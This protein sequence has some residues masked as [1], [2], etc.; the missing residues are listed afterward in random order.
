MGAID[1]CI[2]APGTT[3]GAID[4]DAIRRIDSGEI[5]ANKAFMQAGVDFTLPEKERMRGPRPLLGDGVCGPQGPLARGRGSPLRG[6][7]RRS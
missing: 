4:V 6:R 3:H 5:T 7:V 2:F 1:A